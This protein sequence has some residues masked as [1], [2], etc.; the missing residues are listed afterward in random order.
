MCGIAAKGLLE[1]VPVLYKRGCGRIPMHLCLNLAWLLL[2]VCGSSL[3]SR[4]RSALAALLLFYQYQIYLNWHCF[5]ISH[6]SS[7]LFPFPQRRMLVFLLVAI[8]L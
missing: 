3:F 7:C 6:L 2:A 8:I 1:L 5:P 4:A